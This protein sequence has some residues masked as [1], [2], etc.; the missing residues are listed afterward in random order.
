MKWCSLVLPPPQFRHS[1]KSSLHF[2]RAAHSETDMT[3]EGSRRGCEESRG[4]RGHALRTG[5]AA[6]A[7]GF[8]LCLSRPLPLLTLNPWPR[9]GLISTGSPARTLAHSLMQRIGA[10]RKEGSVRRREG[11]Y[12]LEK[13][14]PPT[15]SFSLSHRAC[16]AAMGTS[17]TTVVIGA[18]RLVL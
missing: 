2:H 11:S 7:W 8:S 3:W 1:G 10:C 5:S 18:R 13:A 15:P 9:V 14:S 16:T 4:L 12:G 6:H 17:P